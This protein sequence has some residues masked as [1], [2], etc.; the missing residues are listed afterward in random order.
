MAQKNN[1]RDVYVYADL[2]DLKEPALMGVLHSELL[3]GKEVF[4]FEYEKNWLQSEHVQLLDPD[5]QLFSGK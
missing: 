3:R 1:K 4:S 5:L 2:Y